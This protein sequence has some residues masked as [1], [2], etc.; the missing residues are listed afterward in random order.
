MAQLQHWRSGTEAQA[1]LALLV[2]AM[3]HAESCDA[4]ARPCDDDTL[5]AVE[6]HLACPVTPRCLVSNYRL[7]N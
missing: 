7:L 2:D 5:M 1:W 4:N 3:V 6:A